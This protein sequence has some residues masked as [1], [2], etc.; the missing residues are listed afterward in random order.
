MTTA[1]KTRSTKR[2]NRPYGLLARHYAAVVPGIDAMNR[3]ARGQ[4]LGPLL[5]AARSVCDVGIGG[6]D[7]LLDLA[8]A[9]KR[10]FGVDNSPLFLRAARAR[11]RAEGLSARLVRGDLTG[12]TLPEPVDLV[13]CEF[14][15][16]NNLADRRSLG[17][18]CR[19]F[20]R[21]LVPGGHL[22][23]DV[24]SPL[25]FS[26]QANTTF[27]YDTREFKLTLRGSLEEGGL[28]ARLDLEWFLPERGRYRHVRETIFNVCWTDEEIRTALEG[29][30]L[31]L[32]G[33]LDGVD[34]RPPFPGAQRGT[35]LYYLARKPLKP[36]SKLRTKSSAPA[37]RAPIR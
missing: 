34:V 9:K 15:S 28:V 32:V 30:G 37:K 10:T 35:D 29:A 36:S 11:L 26:A 2:T 27:W 1:A 31:E 23:F 14:A 33:V 25:A 5:D 21:A 4:V 8:R 19:S 13:L 24:N 20:A 12:F 7:T 6:G 18:A 22:A 3:H 17:A 16:L